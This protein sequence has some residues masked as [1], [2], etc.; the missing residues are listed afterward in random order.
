MIGFLIL[1]LIGSFGGFLAGIM[2]VGGGLVFIPVLTFIF[3]QFDLLS[4]TEIVRF[5]LAN[6]I[7]LVFISGISGVYRQYKMG[8]Y[9]PIESLSVGIPGAIFASLVSF[10]IQYGNWYNHTRFSYVFLGFLLISIGNMLFK[11][12]SNS[13]GNEGRMIKN[14]LAGKAMVGVL[15]GSV[16][17]L[18][19][20]GGGIIMVPMFRMLLKLPVKRATA[21]SLSV[22]PLLAIVPIIQYVTDNQAPILKHSNLDWLNSLPLIQTKYIL[23]LVYIPMAIG[24]LFFSS[25]GQ[26]TSKRIPTRYIQVIFAFLSLII[27]L[28]TVYELFAT[29]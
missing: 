1:L 10:S 26:K 15:A 20:L 25:F 2:G 8:I 22:V 5:T 27:L 9:N 21:L 11:K 14:S 29:I 19:G 7:A 4:N 3:N 24:V 17:A 28:K 23:W 6:S 18:S 13:H 16:V 12:D